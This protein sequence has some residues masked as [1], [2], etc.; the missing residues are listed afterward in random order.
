MDGR[1]EVRKANLE[2]AA[3][4]IKQIS[5]ITQSHIASLPKDP[6]L[7]EKL[8]VISRIEFFHVKEGGGCVH[9]NA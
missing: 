2:P 3:K 8:R 9:D 5:E 1:C 6:S 4:K 7:I